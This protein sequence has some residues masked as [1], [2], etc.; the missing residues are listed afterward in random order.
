MWLIWLGATAVAVATVALAIRSR[1]APALPRPAARRVSVPATGLLVGLGRRGG[2]GGGGDR[3]RW[4]WRRRRSVR[5]EAADARHGVADAAAEPP[6]GGR[7]AGDGTGDGRPADRDATQQH[8]QGP[9]QGGCQ[10]QR[11]RAGGR[12]A[13]PPT[14]PSASHTSSARDRRALPSPRRCAGQELRIG[15]RPARTRRGSCCWPASSCSSVT[16][17]SSP[18]DR[19]PDGVGARTRR[20]GRSLEALGSGALELD[21]DR[22]AVGAADLGDGRRA[23]GERLGLLDGH[24]D[25]PVAHAGLDGTGIVAERQGVLHDAGTRSRRSRPTTTTPPTSR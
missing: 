2:A 14:R 12:A 20:V 22:L 23:V 10:Q 15:A 21:L 24:L 4:R 25:P 3:R 6:D 16:P 18:R 8:G 17:P 5:V 1:L 7:R 9:Q 11:H 13:C 19:R